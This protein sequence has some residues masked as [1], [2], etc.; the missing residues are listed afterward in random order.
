MPEPTLGLSDTH[1]PDC[2]AEYVH[3][4]APHKPPGVIMMTTCNCEYEIQHPSPGV[5]VIVRVPPRAPAG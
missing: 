1:C 4:Q 2:G 3:H 5:T